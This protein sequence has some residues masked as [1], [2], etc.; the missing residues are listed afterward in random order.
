MT[1]K[2]QV[3]LLAL[4]IFGLAACGGETPQSAET[5]QDAAVAKEADGDMVR[6][7]ARP[8][9]MFNVDYQII[10]TPVVGSPVSIDLEIQSSVGNESVEIGYQVPDPSALAMDEAQPRTLTRSPSVGE[11]SI[12]ER[13]TVVPQREG[14]LYINV[15]ASRSGG[16]GSNSTMISIPIHVGDVDT[17][18]QEH[19]QL[20]TDEEGESTRVLDGT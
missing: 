20:E 17:S 1:R 5:G 10:G 7:P 4:L 14:R 12:R 3:F 9:T 15:R 19:G 16:D 18:L 8:G 6:V 13:I 11:R 2:T